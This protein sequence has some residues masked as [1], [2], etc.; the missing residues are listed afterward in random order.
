MNEPALEYYYNIMNLCRL[1]DLEM[2]SNAR[3]LGHL[4]DGLRPTLVGRIQMTQHKRC[5]E[6]LQGVIILLASDGVS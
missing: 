1:V 2:S 4:F 3:I 5:E 6:F